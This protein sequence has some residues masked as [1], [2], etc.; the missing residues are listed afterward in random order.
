MTAY[1]R[2][3]CSRD[4][5]RDCHRADQADDQRARFEPAK[6][7]RANSNGDQKRHPN[8]GIAQTRHEQIESRTRPLLVNGVK[9]GLVHANR[10]QSDLSFTR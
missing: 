3:Q 4:Q 2:F 10:E 1:V 8:L 5:S 6:N 9:K 7:Q